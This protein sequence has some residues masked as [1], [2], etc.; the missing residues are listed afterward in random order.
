MFQKGLKVMMVIG[1]LLLVGLITTLIIR[2][3][4]AENE[5]QKT[6]VVVNK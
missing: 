5:V 4:Q 6:E 3:C 2:E 1:T